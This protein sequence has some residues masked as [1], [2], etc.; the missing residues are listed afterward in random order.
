MNKKDKERV[1]KRRAEM[2]A[3]S[4]WKEVVEWSDKH[5]GKKCIITK[6]DHPWNGYKGTWKGVDKTE[7]GTVIE[8][9][10]GLFRT[11]YVFSIL[12]LEFVEHE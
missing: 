7:T 8:I 5:K 6:K 10:L 1:A 11:C 12:D 2:D 3:E 9:Q 4:G